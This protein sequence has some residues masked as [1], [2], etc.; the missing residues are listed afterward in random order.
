MDNRQDLEMLEAQD[1][2]H[3]RENRRDPRPSS[4][5][6]EP[7]PRPEKVPLT[8]RQETDFGMQSAEQ[9]KRD[10]SIHESYEGFLGQDVR[11]IRP[12]CHSSGPEDAINERSALNHHTEASSSLSPLAGSCSGDACSHRD[13]RSVE[14][15]LL[16]ENWQL[17]KDVA[18]EKARAESA[19]VIKNDAIARARE[20]Q[21]A[22]TR[23]FRQQIA[24]LQQENQRLLAELEDARSHIFSLQSYRKDVT[25]EDV[26]RVRYYWRWNFVL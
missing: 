8:H 21:E 10:H 17:R 18:A 14:L 5:W 16:R 9:R 25:P 7:P 3:Q 23:T 20:R 11:H 12:A 19:E 26:G 2:S 1:S 4:G 22:S 15:N 6:S 13:F 24:E